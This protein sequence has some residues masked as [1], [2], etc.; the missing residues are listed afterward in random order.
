M[1]PESAEELRRYIE[2]VEYPARTEEVVAGAEE[3]GAPQEV[4]EQLRSLGPQR[5]F[6]GPEAVVAALYRP[7][8]GP[9]QATG[10]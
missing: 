9:G 2:G 10:P 6:P 7:P 4:I 5:H 3:R 8:P 1:A